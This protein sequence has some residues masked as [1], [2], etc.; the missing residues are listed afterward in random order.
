MVS[1]E[2]TL[3]CFAHGRGDRWEAICVD[4]EIAVEGRSLDDVRA[5][6]AESIRTY[7][8]DAVAEGQ[9]TTE[10]LLRRKTPFWVR[11]RLAAAYALYAARERRS[12]DCDLKAGFDL[13][14]PA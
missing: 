9:P 11:W 8:E 3:Q 12:L 14:C 7:V 13:L 5:I 1:H 4:F 2:R 10:R 6:L